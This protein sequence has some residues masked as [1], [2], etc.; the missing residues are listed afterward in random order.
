VD[1]VV[2]G[3]MLSWQS[4][5]TERISRRLIAPDVFEC[6]GAMPQKTICQLP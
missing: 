1:G 5:I 3:A 2:S 6:K 4:S